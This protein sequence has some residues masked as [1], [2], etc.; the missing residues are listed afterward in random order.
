MCFVWISEQAGIIS[1]YNINWMVFIT[2]TECVYCAV[3]TGYIY[4]Y[5]FLSKYICSCQNARC[6]NIKNYIYIYIYTHTFVCAVD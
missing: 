4:I 3:R 5:M 1:L 2:E 6:N